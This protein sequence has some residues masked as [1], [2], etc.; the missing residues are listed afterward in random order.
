MSPLDACTL[1][2]TAA[3]CLN[4]PA[5]PSIAQYGADVTQGA[6]NLIGAYLDGGPVA[7]LGLLIVLFVFRKVAGFIAVLMFAE[8]KDSK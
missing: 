2:Q 6:K 4:A 5:A 1:A 8:R 3:Q 7:W